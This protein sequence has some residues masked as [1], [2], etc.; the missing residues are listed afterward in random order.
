M[1]VSIW[2]LRHN[3]DNTLGNLSRT[4]R[5]KPMCSFGT[6]IL[7]FNFN[8]KN[9]NKKK[10]TE[11]NKENEDKSFLSLYADTTKN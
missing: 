1:I 8:E 4:L 3:L 6:E 10:E 5:Q 9:I 2:I 11:E 7:N